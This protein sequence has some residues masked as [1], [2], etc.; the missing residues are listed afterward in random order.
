M[1]VTYVLK[2]MR[3]HAFSS[4]GWIALALLLAACSLT[5][6]DSTATPDA[7]TIQFQFPTDGVAV[8]AGTDLQ[9]GL[10]AQDST[11]IAR[12]ELSVD[13]VPHQSATPVENAAV[14]VFTVS[15]NWL[16][17]GIGLHSLTAVAIRADGSAS[18]PATIRVQVTGNSD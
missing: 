12:V 11:G 18:D 4:H 3:R 14:P 5:A 15:M 17:R 10:L 9:I 1:R 2:R 8:A 13:D 16:A 7:P 6:G